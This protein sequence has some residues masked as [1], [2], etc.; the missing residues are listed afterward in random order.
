MKI[1]FRVDS[2]PVAQPR[3][4]VAV[5]QDREGNVIR[6]KKSGRAVVTHH[7]PTAHPIHQFKYAVRTSALETMEK[8]GLQPIED[9]PVI[10][11]ARFSIPRPAWADAMVGRGK[12]K[13]PKYGPGEIRCWK[14]PDLDNLEKAVKDALKGVAWHD[15]AQVV[16]YGPRHG[17]FYHA[18][19]D[20]PHV[21]IAIWPIDPVDPSVEGP[22]VEVVKPHAEIEYVV[23]IEF[24]A[25]DED[26][27]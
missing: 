18:S 8:L 22:K 7:I 11:E 15:D 13:I 23:P 12:A 3:H 10:L 5:L 19:G 9:Q 21:D 2:M 26:W 16:A 6:D 4:K 25:Y 20:V 17:K 1:V 27:R 24:D 14:K